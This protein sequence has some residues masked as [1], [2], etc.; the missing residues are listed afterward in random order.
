MF[1]LTLELLV[2]VPATRTKESQ[3]QQ[4]E[5]NEKE[6]R[7][8]TEAQG[9]GY[10]LLEIRRLPRPT[11]GGSL[12]S[13]AG[14]GA[15]D[16][17][18]S[19]RLLQTLAAAADPDQRRVVQLLKGLLVADR[20]LETLITVAEMTYGPDRIGLTAWAVDVSVR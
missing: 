13:N 10:S 16:L 9:S 20:R 2:H 14:A 12:D 4:G 7:R 5:K 6:I 19:P 1:P 3:N 11:H 8:R 17:G 15:R 18:A